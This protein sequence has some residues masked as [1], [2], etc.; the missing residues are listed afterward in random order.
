[1]EDGIRGMNR[2]QRRLKNQRDK[3]KKP[4]YS[5]QD[6]QKAI[7]IAIEMKKHSKGH[8]FSAQ[9]KDRCV[10]CGAIMKTRKQCDYW[11]M[12]L[13]DRIQTVL[14]NPAFFRDDEVQA[15]WLQHGEEYQNIKLPLNVGHAKKT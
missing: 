8:L 6:V 11:A 10:F 13:I 12:T 15:L 9:L 7:N 2:A 5:L 14:I 4:K 1:M 3:S